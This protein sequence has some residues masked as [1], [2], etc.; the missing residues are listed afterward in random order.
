VSR[1][2][3]ATCELVEVGGYLDPLGNDFWGVQTFV[4]EDGFTYILGSDGDSG[5][6]IFRDP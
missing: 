2:R 1:E 3:N 5:L 6:W 4:G